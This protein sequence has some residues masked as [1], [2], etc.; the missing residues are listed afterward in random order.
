MV[1]S[2][3]NEGR[4]SPTRFKWRG[5]KK[6]YQSILKFQ[7]IPEESSLSSDQLPNAAKEEEGEGRRRRRSFGRRTK[8]SK[9]TRRMRDLIKVFDRYQPEGQPDL[10]IDDSP[11]H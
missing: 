3:S 1:S 2:I 11:G 10:Y 5:E 9:R 6:P 8:A 4:A 7:K